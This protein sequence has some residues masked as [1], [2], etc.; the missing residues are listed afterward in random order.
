MLVAAVSV[1]S[2]ADDP[3]HAYTREDLDRM[4]GPV[5]ESAASQ[6]SLSDNLAKS[7][8]DDWHSITEFIDRE[9]AHALAERQ[10]TP[11]DYGD[12]RSS[13]DYSS[14]FYYPGVWWAPNAY[15]YASHTSYLG[16]GQGHRG[17]SP[18]IRFDSQDFRTH[19]RDVSLYRGHL[20]LMGGQPN[21]SGSRH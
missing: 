19:Q 12:D 5:P 8:A 9:R 13:S 11:I 14:S 2:A 21:H 1:V 7:T 15:G 17:T 20:H 6:R 10:A 16:R 18:T 3:P 4:F